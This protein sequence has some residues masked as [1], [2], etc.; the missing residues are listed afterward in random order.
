MSDLVPPITQETAGIVASAPVSWTQAMSRAIRSPL[1]LLEA[2]DLP[3]TGYIEYDSSFRT[4]VP[5]EFLQRMRLGDPTDPLLL[6]VLPQSEE[7]RVAPG[8]VDDAVGDLQSL[9]APGLI[10][11]YDGRAL[12][13]ASGACGVH[14]RY[15]FRRE[16]PYEEVASRH[17]RWKPA[18]KEIERS[19]DIQEVILSGGDPLT[20][21]DDSFF[22]LVSQI[23][24]IPHV[25]RIRI[26]SRMPIVIPQR[27]TDS[28][29]DRLVKLRATAWFVIHANH[30]NELDKVVLDRLAKLIDRGIPVLNQAVLLNRINDDFESLYDL[31][32]RLVNNR[33]SPYY[34]H[35]LDRVRG[36]HHF[37]V[38]KSKGLHLIDQLCAKL[39][40]YAVPQYVIEQPGKSSKTPIID[41]SGSC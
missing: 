1:K 12:L 28:F 27:L 33:I 23:D 39:P 35:Q 25:D 32:L 20:L 6:Q 7:V 26:H 30:A 10:H 4:F 29:C 22:E 19:P 40:G 31:M 18:I 16:F 2:L 21:V 15:C 37:E 9:S 17:Q 14:C 8:F 36:T 34:L 24:R 13:I 3:L 41:P 11:K 5:L 38:S